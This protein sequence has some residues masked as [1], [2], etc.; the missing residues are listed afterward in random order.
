MRY[1]GKHPARSSAMVSTK[2]WAKIHRD[3]IHGDVTYDPLSVALLDTPSLQ[4]L[5]RIYQLGYAHLVYRGATHTRLSH[6]MGAAHVATRFA[7]SLR[8]NYDSLVPDN[9]PQGVVA[10]E[11]FLPAAG[12]DL[13]DRWEILRYLVRWAALLH[14]VGHVPLGHT[15]EDEFDKI[16]E[17]HDSF[18]S[19]RIPYLWH[20]SRPGQFSDIHNVLTNK[21]LYPRALSDID[22]TSVLNT[23]ML[24]VLH[25]RDG[26]RSD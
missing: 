20:Q 23:V 8:S 21:G 19:P 5:G 3:E 7:D 18:A 14:D 10:P 6:V 12:K 26:N 25:R 1:L 17:K 9:L 2:N 15:L 4:R 16:Y 24:I 11:E 13:T 22:T